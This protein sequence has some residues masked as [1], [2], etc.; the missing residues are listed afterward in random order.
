MSTSNSKIMGSDPLSKNLLVACN[1]DSS[2]KPIEEQPRYAYPSDFGGATTVEEFLENLQEPCSTIALEQDLQEQRLERNSW[3]GSTAKFEPPIPN[4]SR[5]EYEASIQ[6]AYAQ[7][8]PVNKDSLDLL[9]NTTFP[10]MQLAPQR[11]EVDATIIGVFVSG[12]GGGSLGEGAV[13]MRSIK[14]CTDLCISLGVPM[15]GTTTPKKGIPRDKFVSFLS[16]ISPYNRFLAYPDEGFVYQEWCFDL[17]KNR[18]KTVIDSER[19]AEIS[20]GVTYAGYTWDSDDKSRAN[21]T[22]F[23]AAN[24]ETTVEW[25]TKDNLMITIDVAG[26]GKALTEHVTAC[27]QRSWDRKEALQATT[28]EEEVDAI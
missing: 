1:T 16:S 5:Q 27:F 21:V 9:L 10:N 13:A 15:T 4:T 6:N 25:R 23:L 19:N 28:T 20:S 3:I 17:A 12:Y 24:T 22:N 2:T 18:K 8:P 26:L 7:Y 14:E 11:R